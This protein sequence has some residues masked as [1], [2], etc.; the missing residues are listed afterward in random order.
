[1][2]QQ[3]FRAGELSLGWPAELVTAE[4]ARLMD[5]APVATVRTDGSGPLDAH[6]WC[7]EVEHF[8][9]EAFHGD[10]PVQE[11][12]A[13]RSAAGGDH[14]DLSSG[15][16]IAWLRDLRTLIEE[17]PGPRPR[18]VYW[19]Q[20]RGSSAPRIFGLRE[21][22][23]AFAEVVGALEEAGYLVW[24]FGQACVDQP[25]PGVLGEDP[26]D[27]VHDALGRTGLWP[28]AAHHTTYTRDDL[29]DVIEFL[30]HHVRRPTRSYRHDYADCGRHFDGFEPVRGLQLYRV[31]IND[32]LRLS[33]LGLELNES[34]LLEQAAPVGLGSLVD[35]SLAGPS[36]HTAD[37]DELRHAVEQFRA[38]DASALDMRHAVIAL[39]GIL[40]RRRAL[41]SEKM[42]S[43]DAGELF[44][45]ANGYGIRHQKADQKA[46]YDPRLYLEWTFYLFLGAIHLTDRI[47]AGQERPGPGEE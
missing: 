29:A 23:R 27:A 37:A 42:L 33:D 14:A 47:I 11:W 20:R 36:V 8:L 38:R 40:E 7:K 25:R 32:V 35:D 13:V 21:T 15:R 4:L 5:L 19:T 44:R 18:P 26:A 1:M 17:L 41:V 39:S 24:A 12:D 9:R 30:A 45:I 43:K 46:D 2:E 28:P 10:A 3:P 34:G 6:R 31:R 22:A 16:E